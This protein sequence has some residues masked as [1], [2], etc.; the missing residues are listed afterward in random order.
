MMKEKLVK[1]L[2]QF[3]TERRRKLIDNVLQQRT[4]YITVVLEDIYQSQNASAVLRT[5]ECLGIQD[6]HI[7]ENRNLY[8]V[9][10]DVALGSFK[11][12]TLHKYNGVEN[13]TGPA[14]EH[15]K[16]QGYRIIATSPDPESKPIEELDLHEGRIALLFGTELEGLSQ[17]AIQLSD[18]SVRIPLYGF[19]QSYNIS[20]AAAITLYD[21]VSRLRKS[22]IAWNLD[23]KELIHLKL[24]WLRNSI[25]HPDIMDRFL[26]DNQKFDPE[27]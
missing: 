2:Q 9:N 11:W 13:N 1:Y 25:R 5:C 6:V 15:L 10:P 3:V 18:M 12:L 8:Q 27:E 21:L 4:R 20:V 7:I 19:T 16:C 14:V 24:Q 17:E 26:I 22:S 23:E